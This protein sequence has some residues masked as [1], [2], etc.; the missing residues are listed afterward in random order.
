MDDAGEVARGEDYHAGTESYALRELRRQRTTNTKTTTTTTTPVPVPVPRGLQTLA[1]DLGVVGDGITND[2]PAIQ[3][4]IDR[5]SSSSSS[6]GGGG[7]GGI[8]RLPPGIFRTYVPLMIPGGITLV[9]TGY[10]SSPLA[11]Q[12]DAGG[13]TIAYCGSDYAIKMN[14][15][16]SSLRELAVYNW[17]Y[18]VECVDASSSG[19][20]LVDANAR[21]IESAYLSNVLIYSFLNGS[22]LELRATNGGGIAYGNYQNLRIR[23]AR[24]GI[25][26]V[27]DE[28]S[29]VK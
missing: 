6:V 24:T 11:L 15:H 21:L 16:G 20:V 14:G 28:R 10:G 8:V 18:G 22:G 4:A 27:A 1:M 3:S 7:G 9:G 12:F 23:H 5:A 13:S 25:R 2:G 17:R 26:L 29:F 19:G